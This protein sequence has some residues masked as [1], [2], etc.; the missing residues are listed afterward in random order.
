[1]WVLSGTAGRLGIP[2]GSPDGWD[3][4][5]VTGPSTLIKNGLVSLLSETQ[6]LGLCELPGCLGTELTKRERLASLT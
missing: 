3:W 6:L 2:E 1:M 4:V 5:K